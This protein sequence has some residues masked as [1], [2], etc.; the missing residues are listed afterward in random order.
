MQKGQ[1]IIEALVLTLVLASL[2]IAIMWL[3]RLQDIA[4]HLSHASR[5][6]AFRF[7]YQKI[8]LQAEN[9]LAD[10]VQNNIWL[11]RDGSNLIN[12]ADFILAETQK[13]PYI[14]ADK[15][16]ATA[17][18]LFNQLELGDN[19]IWQSTASSDTGDL[20]QNFNSLAKFDRQKLQISRF[21]AIMRASPSISS[22]LQV[23]NKLANNPILWA[24]QAQ[25]SIPLGQS[26]NQALQKIDSAWAR[27]LPEW[28]WIN[29]WVS[30][31]PQRH[32]HKSG[33]L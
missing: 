7:A 21:T 20:E 16:F 12:S 29:G 4:L 22:D 8:D 17:I 1:A 2:L 14:S 33:D 18:K 3:G 23:Q 9:N 10:S 5:H 15:K 27:S 19:A 24:D 6:N 32:L 31:M 28:D 25:R 13:K 30:S 26:I 11:K